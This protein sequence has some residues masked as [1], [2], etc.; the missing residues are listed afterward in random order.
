ML[1]RRN[2]DFDLVS[3]SKFSGW[4]CVVFD[5]EANLPP[6]SQDHDIV[7]AFDADPSPS[8]LWMAASI[9]RIQIRR[10]G[11]NGAASS[12]SRQNLIDL[13]HGEPDLMLPF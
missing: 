7:L 11:T 10:V 9:L 5:Q 3:Q 12:E 2:E 4:F 8:R 1:D 13:R 6:V